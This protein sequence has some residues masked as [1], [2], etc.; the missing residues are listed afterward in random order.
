MHKSQHSQAS[1]S[2]L[3]PSSLKTL[4]L[5]HSSTP[6]N[7]KQI[8]NYIIPLGKPDSYPDNETTLCNESKDGTVLFPI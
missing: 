3:T 6:A 5:S 7:F 8:S 4:P 2:V 1:K